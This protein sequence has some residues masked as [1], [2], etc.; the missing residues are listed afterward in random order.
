MKNVKYT[1]KLNGK[2]A[3]IVNTSIDK[4]TRDYIY[5]YKYV[6]SAERHVMNENCFH[7]L[8]TLERTKN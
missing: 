3:I 5:T 6:G 1:N 8:F 2:I 4:K 7:G